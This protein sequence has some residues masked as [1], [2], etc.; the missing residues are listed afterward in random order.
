MPATGSGPDPA[1]ERVVGRIGRP[2]GLRGEVTVD[3]RTDSP[4]ER[5]ALGSVLRAG[6]RTL[7]VSSLRPHSGRLLVTFDGVADRGAAEQLRG[8]LLTVDTASLPPTEDPDEFHDHQLE[9]LVAVRPDGTRLGTVRDV[10]H[11]PAHDLL[12]LDTAAGEALVPFV[13][14]IVPEVDLSTGRLVV[15]PPVG[16]LEEP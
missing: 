13:R 14:P 5:F 3:V 10:M 16:L 11:A 8:I 2:H 12:V 9:G 15:D 1:R 4:D 6:A 7:T